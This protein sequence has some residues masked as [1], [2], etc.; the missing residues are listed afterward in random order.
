MT[1]PS[2]KPAEVQ[3]VLFNEDL[4]NIGT[5]VRQP[6]VAIYAFGDKTGQKRQNSGGGTSFSSA[7]TQAPEAYLIRALK[8]QGMENSSELLIG[9]Y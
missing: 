2:Y 8:G 1:I 5:P 3:R 9:V 7:V 6:T 4:V